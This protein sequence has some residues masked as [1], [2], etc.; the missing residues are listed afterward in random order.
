MSKRSKSIDM[1]VYFQSPSSIIIN[2]Y[3]CGDNL[4]FSFTSIY[5]NHAQVI[6][7]AY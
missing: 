4:N 6:F 2:S 7:C 5:F 3:N 1:H